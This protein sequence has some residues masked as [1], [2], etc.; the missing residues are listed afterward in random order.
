[1][2]KMTMKRSRALGVMVAAV[3][4]AAGCGSSFERFE[5]FDQ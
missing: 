4:F 3:V 1:M 2:S 5:Q